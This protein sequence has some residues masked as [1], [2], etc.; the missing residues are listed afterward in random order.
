MEKDAVEALRE[1]FESFLVDAEKHSKGNKLAGKR[2]RVASV[3]I[4]EN[5]KQWRLDTLK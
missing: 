3:K 4:R 1:Q 5:L 2:A